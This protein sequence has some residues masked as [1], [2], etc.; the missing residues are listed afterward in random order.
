MGWG[1]PNPNPNLPT[2]H[3]NSRS[4]L[5]LQLRSDL[6]DLILHTLFPRQVTHLSNPAK[7]TFTER[8]GCLDQHVRNSSDLVAGAMMITGKGKSLPPTNPAP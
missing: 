1:N 8:F 5:G 6:R 2:T 4:G 3:L 7:F